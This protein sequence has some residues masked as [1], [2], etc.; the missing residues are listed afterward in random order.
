M[1]EIGQQVIHYREGISVIE[2][3]TK[4]NNLDYFVVSSSINKDERFFVLID[5]T[6][7]IIRPL[8]NEDEAK[9]VI[10]FMATIQPDFIKNTKQRRDCYKRCLTTGK[11]KDLCYLYKQ[12]YFFRT[13]NERG[14]EV[15]MGP[16]D[17]QMLEQ[18]KKMLLNEL[19]ISLSSNLADVEASIIKTFEQES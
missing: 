16:S 9:E 19:V 14:E 7:N 2:S 18:A 12:L 8:M 3:T 5:K 4:I 11:A 1:F 15:K 6:E 17:L 10:K 13:F